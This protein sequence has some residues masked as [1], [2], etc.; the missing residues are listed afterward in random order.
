MTVAPTGTR[1]LQA[2]NAVSAL[3]IWTEFCREAEDSKGLLRG[4]SVGIG[5]AHGRALAGRIGTARQAKV[6]VFGPVVN[7]GS[8]LEGM[9]KQF[10]V[11]ICIDETTAQFV[12]RFPL[13]S[14]TRVRRLARVYPMGMDTPLTPY[15]LM[16][17]ES[18]CPEITD[19][20]L[21]DHEEALEAVAQGRWSEAIALLDRL[22]E[23]DG[24]AMFLRSY[25]AEEKQAPSD[26][27]GVI[28]LKTK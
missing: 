22:P 21:A 15:V 3:A 7:R 5:V 18:Q 8:R 6:G 13:P 20:M 10:G 28:P 12:K 14:G 27:D 4:F 9:T 1:P 2:A 26:W 17:P 25:L 11:P 19:E 23:D 24:P 16:P